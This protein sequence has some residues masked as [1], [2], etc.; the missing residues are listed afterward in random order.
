MRIQDITVGAF[1]ANR[2]HTTIRQVLAIEERPWSDFPALSGKTG[3]TPGVVFTEWNRL[4]EAQQTHSTRDCITL[5]SFARWAVLRTAGPLSFPRGRGSMEVIYAD[6]HLGRLGIENVAP[7][8][9]PRRAV[10]CGRLHNAY[11]LDVQVEGT[12]P[13]KAQ[14]ACRDAI[15][16]A[17]QSGAFNVLAFEEALK[18]RRRE[19][20]DVDE[21]PVDEPAQPSP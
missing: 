13:T 5:E 7:A 2:D 18:M 21:E 11:G 20:D 14:Q 6:V 12:S 19:Y 10:L 8:F 16:E 4:G 15:V 3:T 1:Y 17:I 9:E